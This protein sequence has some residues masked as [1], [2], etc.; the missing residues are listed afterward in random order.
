MEKGLVLGHGGRDGLE[1]RVRVSGAEHDSGVRMR[2][3]DLGVEGG[4]RHVE[5]AAVRGEKGAPLGLGN[6]LKITDYGL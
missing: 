6:L 5:A 2:S 1:P 3:Q 4:E